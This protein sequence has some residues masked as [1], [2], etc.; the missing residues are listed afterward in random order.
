MKTAIGCKSFTTQ[1]HLRGKGG[2][3]FAL[4]ELKV[5]SGEW[6]ED[7]SSF[8]HR[9]E[10]RMHIHCHTRAPTRDTKPTGDWAD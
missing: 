7:Y 2:V 1:G 8:P 5:E 4:Q 9:R 10:S 3:A 6:G